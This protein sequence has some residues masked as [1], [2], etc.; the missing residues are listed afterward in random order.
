MGRWSFA[1]PHATAFGHVPDKWSHQMRGGTLLAPLIVQP[2]AYT[3]AKDPPAF[4]LSS[5]LDHCIVIFKVARCR[6]CARW[7]RGRGLRSQLVTAKNS[8]RHLSE[9]AVQDPSCHAAVLYWRHVRCRPTS[10][11]AR[12]RPP[13]PVPAQC[14]QEAESLLPGRRVPAVGEGDPGSPDSPHR[15]GP[16]PGVGHRAG[17]A[18]G[19]RDV[20]LRVPLRLHADDRDGGAPARRVSGRGARAH[21]RPASSLHSRARRRPHLRHDRCGGLGGVS[22]AAGLLEH[23]RPVLLT[24]AWR[25]EPRAGLRARLCVPAEGGADDGRQARARRVAWRDDVVPALRAGGVDLRGSQTAG[26]T[27]SRC[28]IVR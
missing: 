11:P 12:P 19:V 17:A 13:W 14:R 15:G 16:P 25:R 23:V 22:V 5:W 3:D 7:V 20:R 18:G 1:A 9:D 24:S 26:S 6:S 2:L 21:D 10:C 28:P 27:P 4:H 8:L